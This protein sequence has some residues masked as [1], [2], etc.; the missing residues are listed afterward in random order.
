MKQCTMINTLKLKQMTII[1]NIRFF[2]IIKYQKIM[3]TKRAYLQY[4]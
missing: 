2:S 4:Y 1:D 3:N